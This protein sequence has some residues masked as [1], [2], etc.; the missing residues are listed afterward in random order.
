MLHVPHWDFEVAFV[1]F[2]QTVL[3]LLILIPIYIP[4]LCLDLFLQ[5]FAK[6]QEMSQKHI[7]I[8]G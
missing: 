1:Q 8:A 7:Y 2:N 5:L 3:F 4:L 6:K